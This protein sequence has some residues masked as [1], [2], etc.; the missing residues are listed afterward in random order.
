ML[1][2]VGGD[3]AHRDAALACLAKVGG[4]LDCIAAH[5]DGARNQAALQRFHIGVARELHP[6]AE[7]VA[8]EDGPTPMQ[9]EPVS[10]SGIDRVLATGFRKLRFPP[11][12]EARFEKD[13]GLARSHYLAVSA[14]I[15][16]SLNVFYI[17]RDRTVIGDVYSLA[18]LIRFGV[19]VPFGFA[20]CFV[21]CL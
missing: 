3:G 18:L 13:T 21:V 16:L 6:S 14:A 10:I 19:V 9:D 7:T 5:F 12:L 8:V 2:A 1:V 15:L 17:A 4:R 20:G 11:A